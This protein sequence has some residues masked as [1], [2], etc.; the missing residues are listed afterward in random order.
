[1]FSAVA[2]KFFRFFAAANKVLRSLL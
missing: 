2:N 1:M